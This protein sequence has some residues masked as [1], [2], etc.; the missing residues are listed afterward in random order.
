M[1][2]K[3]ILSAVFF[4]TL[5]GNTL[6]AQFNLEQFLGTARE[7]ISL[8]P[9]KAKIDFLEENNYNGPWIS[10]VEMRTRSDDANL[11]QEDFRFRLTPSNPSELKANKRY[12]DK[13]VSLLNTEYQDVLNTALKQR[14]IIAV[15]HMFESFKM[16]NLEK[17]LK[18]NRQLIEMINSGNGI[19]SMD[20]GD[21]VDAQSDELDLSLSIENTRIA[22][23]EIEYLMKEFYPFSGEINWYRSE[24]MEISDILNLFEEFKRRP[25]GQHVNLVKLEQKNLLAAERFNIEKSESMRNI[26][27]FQAEYDL[28]RGDDP[29]EHFGYQIGIRIPIVNPDKPDL[30]RRKLETMDDEALLDERQDNYRRKMELS[31]LRMDRYATQYSEISEKLKLLS[32]QNFLNFQRMDKSVDISDLIKINEFHM[33][34]LDKKNGVEKK[35]FENYLEYLDLCGLLVETP[36][37]NYLAKGLPEF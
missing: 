26:G 36:L 8:N 27:Y 21:L 37:R 9:A 4:V 10:R 35:I 22:L 29:S 6:L 15:D 34:L 2:V 11:S 3:G 23:D 12:Y 33:E 7:D 25:S 30:N 19:Y 16:V 32:E 24:L 17:Q 31:V 5:S 28:E 13:Q 1:T 18:I 14:Y 20:M